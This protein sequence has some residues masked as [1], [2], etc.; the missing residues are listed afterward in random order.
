MV[1]W[2]WGRGM[3]D[4]KNC[5]KKDILLLIYTSQLLHTSFLG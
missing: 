1:F 5:N 3:A 2:G 4:K